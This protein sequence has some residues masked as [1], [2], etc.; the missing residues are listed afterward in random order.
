MRDQQSSQQQGPFL[1]DS[2][3]ALQNDARLSQPTNCCKWD[4]AACQSYWHISSNIPT[5]HVQGISSPHQQK[6]RLQ[7]PAQSTR[8]PLLETS[9]STVTYCCP[10]EDTTAQPGP[11][12]S[13]RLT[14]KTTHRGPPNQGGL[15]YSII[16]VSSMQAAA[17]MQ[18]QVKIQKQAATPIHCSALQMFSCSPTSTL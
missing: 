17:H 16:R 2:F 18:C 14:L 10:N 13:E 4:S 12:V 15:F 1:S 7:H 6:H 9:T 3:P 8:L 5:W 11:P